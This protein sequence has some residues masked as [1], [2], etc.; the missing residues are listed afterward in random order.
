MRISNLEHVRYMCQEAPKFIDG[1]KIEKAICWL[2]FIQGV[3]FVEAQY[4]IEDLKNH[5]RKGK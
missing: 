1:G 3:L 5:S 2:G 4:S